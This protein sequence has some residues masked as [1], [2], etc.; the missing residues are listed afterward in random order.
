M[1]RSENVATPFTASTI[2]VPARPA[3]PGLAPSAIVTGPVK[4]GT[5]FPAASS[6]ATCTAGVMAEPAWVVRGC[7][8]NPRCVAA[9]GGGRGALMSNRSL[10]APVA[11]AVVARSVY[12]L[13]ALST[14]KSV[15]VATPFTAFILAVPNRAALV[16]F[17]SSPTVTGPLNVVA[18]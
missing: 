13:P 15:N 3:L 4:A 1:L 12:P 16:G 9:G 11:P 6:A 5:T 18:G 10:V 17:A 7:W 2:F 14:L 8:A